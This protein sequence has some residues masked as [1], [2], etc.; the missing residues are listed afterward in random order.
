MLALT[1]ERTIAT[2]VDPEGPDDEH[3]GGRNGTD[4]RPGGLESAAAAG[5]VPVAPA[6]NRDDPCITDKINN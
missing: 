5:L 4:Q 1:A 6:I 2:S 3:N